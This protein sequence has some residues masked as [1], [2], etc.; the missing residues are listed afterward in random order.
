LKVVQDSGAEVNRRTIRGKMND[1][2]KLLRVRT[3]DGSI[4]LRES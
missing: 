4:R 1:G 2:G 3:G